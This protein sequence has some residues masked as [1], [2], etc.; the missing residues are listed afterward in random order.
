MLLLGAAGG[1]VAGVLT[2]LA[3]ANVA[4]AVL[5][6]LTACGAAIA[7]FQSHVGHDNASD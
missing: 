5:G 3:A 4:A 1:A 6:G 2:Y 7:F